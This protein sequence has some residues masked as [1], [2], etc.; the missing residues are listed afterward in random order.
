VNLLEAIARIA[1]AEAAVERAEGAAIE[2]AC[3]MVQE[4]SKSLIGVPKPEWPP[5][6]LSTLRAKGNVNT[7]LLETGNLRE[8]IEFTVIDSRHGE[9]GTNDPVGE[10]HEFGTS[11]GLPPRPFLSLA[12]QQEGPAV[13]K[14]VAQTVGG[15]IGAALGGHSIEAEILKLIGHVAHEVWEDAKELVEPEEPTEAEGARRR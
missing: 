7:P 14:M 12:A 8:S 6:A 11:R 9:V 5:L 4:R 10:F 3:K 15:A 13:A 2:A 1:V